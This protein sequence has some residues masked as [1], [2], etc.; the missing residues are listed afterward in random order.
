M[1]SWCISVI[2]SFLINNDI[3]DCGDPTPDNGVSVMPS[4]TTLNA[5][6]TIT[7]RPG[8]DISGA[9]SLTCLDSG[10]DGNPAC[11]IQGKDKI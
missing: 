6:A 3:S 8:Y 2:H 10:W 1:I 7:C 9:A 5:T 11:V 4:G